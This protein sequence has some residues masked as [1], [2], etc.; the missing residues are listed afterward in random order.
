MIIEDLAIV[1]VD[2][3]QFSRSVMKSALMEFGYMD[4]RLAEIASKTLQILDQ[5][6]AEVVLADWVMPQMN[7]LELTNAI[8][9]KDEERN[10]YTS[11]ILF[12]GKEGEDALVEAFQSGVDDY[13]TK[14]VNEKEL[15]ARVHA[16]GR[17]ASLQNT[18]LETSAA[19]TAA[20][21]HLQKINATDSLTG[22]GNRRYLTR[23]LEGMLLQVKARG[24]GACLAVIDIDDFSGINREHGTDIGD[25]ILIGL[26]RRLRRAI[27]P[28]DMLVRMGGEEFAMVMFYPDP[29]V[30]RASVFA[31][32]LNS[33]SQRAI[34][35]SAGN[36]PVTVSIGVH[37]FADPEQLETVTSMIKK[38]DENLLEAK[39][40]G[41][42]RVI[43]S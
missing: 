4:I 12:T 5:R 37:C 11:V 13:L 2:D 15:A 18:L 10:R 34:K 30:F 19:L 21:E 31:R 6:S 1:I 41:R 25:E 40:Q 36:V 22:L 23:H 9:Q 29:S 27:R 43:T 28:T 14:P 17:I 35:S 32:V 42:N 8:R 26:S 33:V 39:N 3:M 16:A 38:A 7:G 20:N 24:G